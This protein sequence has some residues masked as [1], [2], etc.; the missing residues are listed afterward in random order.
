EQDPTARHLSV[1]DLSVR[2]MCHAEEFYR[3]ADGASTSEPVCIRH[4]LR[5]LVRVHGTTRV[6]EFGPLALKAVRKAM[7]DA[8]LARTTINKHVHRIKRLFAW[9]VENELVPASIHEALRC[10][11]NLKAGRT[12]APEPPAVKPVPEGVVEA[13]LPHLPRVV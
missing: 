7:I 13:T 1:D 12:S 5:F 9:G 3:R 10:V 11:A 6:R 2:Y 4:A 8:G